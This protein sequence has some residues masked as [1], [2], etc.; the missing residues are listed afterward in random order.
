MDDKEIKYIDANNAVPGE[1]TAYVDV[2]PGEVS[3]NAD[4][5]QRR[6][7]NRQIQLI[8]IGGSIGTAL[9]VSI[10][11]GLAKGGPLSLFLAYTIYSAML[12]LVNNCMAEMTCLQPVSGGFIR[13]AGKWVDDAFGFMAGWNFFFYEALLIP[14]EITALNL[15]L[16]FWR[17]DIPTAAVCAACIVLY[18]LI[19]IL[20]VRA[21]GEAEFWL[22]G[23]KV[24]LIFMLF[25]FTFITMVGGNPRHDAYGFRY[26]NNPGPMAEYHT[27]GALGRFEGFLACLWSA[28]FCVVGPEYL[29]MV[30]A[31]AKRPRIYIK[32]AFKTIYWRFGLFFIL[33]SLC[34]GVVIP[35]NDPT[36]VAIVNGT[37]SGGGTAAASPYV[38][39]MKNLKV[40]VL[41]HITNALLVTSI[42][43]A[44]NTYTYCATRSLYGLALESRAPKFLTKCTR[45]G[46]PIWSFCVVMLFPLLSFLQVSSGS[47]QVLTWLINLITAG[48]IIDYIVMCVTYLFFYRACMAQ[49]VDRNTFPY[50]GWFQPYCGWIGLVWMT[51]IVI[52]YGYSSFTPWD[53]GTFF[54]YY[55]MVIVAPVLYMGWKLIK[56][57][58]IVSASEAD[59]V[60]E[61]PIVDAYEATFISPP[62]GFWTEMLQLVGLKRAKKDDR[63]GSIVSTSSR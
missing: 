63:R 23:G 45:N 31:E 33:G 1:K 18:A 62:V 38:I 39:A 53:V 52:F 29:A 19:N 9:F 43:S 15:V 11:G 30:A 10:G 7:N 44:G 34:V 56:R 35:Y 24:I 8:A 28:S 41:P 26:W 50:T 40:E 61:R 12:G 6:L 2:L 57:T 36:L 48:G 60:W 42:F 27:T 3:D 59:L 25:M 55:T 32:K 14:F 54:S 5:L 17:D 51:L 22:S 16:S 49:G 58:K 46:V 20:A 13:M 21:Y 37:Q 47:S 4:K